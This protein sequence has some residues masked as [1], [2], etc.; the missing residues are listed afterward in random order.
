MSV[1]LP[2]AALV[3]AQSGPTTA[4]PNALRA[5]VRFLASDNLEGRG[6][7]SKGLDI[8]ADYIAAQF[9]IIGLEPG[10]NGSYF[11]ET[12]I[13][14]GETVSPVKNVVAVLRGSDPTLRETF[15]IVSAHYDHLGARQGEGDQIYNGA[16]DDASGVAGMIESARLLAA[17]K[18]KR[19]VVFIGF[20][21][22]ER[23]LVGSRF[24][25]QNPVFPLQA[26]V[27]QVNLEQI[28]RTDD[29]EGPRVGA[30]NLTGFDFTDIASYMKPA[31]A[32]AGVKPEKHEKLSDPYFNASDNAPL[33][34][35][36]IPSTTVSTCYTYPDYHR[37]GDHWDKLDYDNFAKIVTAV[38]GGVRAIADSTKAPVWN[39]T[40]P[41]VSRY[42]EA[43]KK[44]AG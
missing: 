25:S 38:A 23:G 7:P 14:R 13:K 44:L 40:N 1:L 21:G 32:K 12:T 19:S 6:T 39:S 9:E 11:Q 28:G 15:V 22:E 16:N 20:Y 36:G 24:Y 18:P 31:A 30:F 43:Q 2:V 17:K 27:A 26:T 34:L 33:A 35:V 37:P 3:L 5:H 10:C 41:K 42:I 8:A 4:A 29:S